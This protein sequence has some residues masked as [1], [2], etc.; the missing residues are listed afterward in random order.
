M[1]KKFNKAAKLD[2]IDQKRISLV[3]KLGC[4]TRKEARQFIRDSGGILSEKLDKHVEI[5]VVGADA[6]P[7]DEPESLLQPWVIEAKNEGRIKIIPEPLFWEQLGID[8]SVQDEGQLYTP[9]MLAR[10]LNVPISTIRRWHRRGL[11][12]PTRQFKKL[13]YFDFQ[14]VASARRIAQLITSGATPQA[15]ETKLSQLSELFPSLNR[16][17]SQLS[18]IVEGK[19]ILLRRGGGLVEPNGQRRIDF[20]SLTEEIANNHSDQDQLLSFESTESPNE[21]TIEDL[22]SPSE[23]VRLAIEYEDRE[24]H[25]SAIQVYRAMALAYGATP[26]VCFRLAELLYLRGDLAGARERYFVAVELDQTFVEARASLG[27]VL[28]ELDEKELALSAFQG[29]LD[30]HSEYPDVH[31]HLARLLDDLDRPDDAENH[32]NTFLQLA[33][34]SPWAEEARDRLQADPSN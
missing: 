34:K 29:A 4:V 15:I 18:V 2:G 19:S 33:P 10:L 12:V 9:S 17:L 23:F 11:I 13:A 30:H 1:P 22:S 21:K 26:S 3:G 6:D 28:V 8:E 32:W 24:D 16:P 27:C 20:D 25:D 31:F 5:I 7:L 14:E